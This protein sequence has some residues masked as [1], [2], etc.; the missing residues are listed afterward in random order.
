VIHDMGLIE[1]V[2][3]PLYGGYA[4][5]LMAPAAFLQRPVRWLR[6]ITRYRATTTGGPNFAYDLCVRRVTDE[7]VAELDLGSWRIA[8]NGAEPIR[9]DTLHAFHERFWKVDGQ[10]QLRASAAS[11]R[12]GTPRRG[13]AAYHKLR[14]RGRH[15]TRLERSRLLRNARRHRRS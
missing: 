1:G 5:Y 4:A 3:G 14:R 9:A 10:R 11:G 8:Y 15:L 12:H 2:L 6:A 13:R 7:Q